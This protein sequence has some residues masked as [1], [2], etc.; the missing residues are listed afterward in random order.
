MGRELKRVAL[1]FNWPQGKIWDGF[2]NPHYKKCPEAGRTCFGGENAAS[3]YLSHITN[4]L[5]L[6]GDDARRGQTH[7]Y[8]ETLPYFSDHPDWSIQP[9]AVRKQMVD[10][11]QKLTGEKPSSL[12]FGGSGCTIFFRLLEM[13]GFKNP[14]YEDSEAYKKAGKPA[15]EWTHCPTCK[16]ENIDPAV[17]EKYDAWK[18]SEPPSGP[19]YQLW[20]T[21]SEGSPISPVFATLDELCAYASEHCSTFADNKTSAESWKR[22]LGEGLVIHREGNMVFL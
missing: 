19:G 1:D 7:H 8:A 6:I 13:A 15:Y 4:M 12:G 18:E 10:L 16:G 21:T 22:M 11:I 2:V 9:E 17:K 3:C 14:P 20:E 5:T